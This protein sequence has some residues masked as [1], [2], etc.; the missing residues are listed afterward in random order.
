[1][2]INKYSGSIKYARQNKKAWL[3]IGS[4]PYFYDNLY[5]WTLDY[6]SIAAWRE[7][8]KD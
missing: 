3:F 5:R 2:R 1:M 7:Q 8:G 4:I 6:Y